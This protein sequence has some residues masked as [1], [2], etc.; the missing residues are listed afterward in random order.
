MAQEMK[1]SKGD[2]QD[3][4]SLFIS[5]SGPD[6][7]CSSID[8]GELALQ[9]RDGGD[10][11][12]DDDVEAVAVEIEGRSELKYEVRYTVDELGGRYPDSM[13]ALKTNDL[14]EAIMEA[15]A[16]TLKG[17]CGFVRMTVDGAIRADD[18]TWIM[19]NES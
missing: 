10:D 4:A 2:I 6:A 12:S 13:L 9:L 3:M 5:E 19:Q 1:L 11:I 17:H 7:D 16:R 18:G 15:C 8:R 14:D